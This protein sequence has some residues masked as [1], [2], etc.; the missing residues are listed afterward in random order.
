VLGREIALP[1]QL[2]IDQAGSGQTPKET[3]EIPV[4]DDSNGLPA[5]GL[6]TSTYSEGSSE[7]IRR[8][9][10][11]M[12]GFMP[13]EPR[14]A[15]LLTPQMAVVYEVEDQSA[16]DDLT[17]LASGSP[18]WPQMAGHLDAVHM[19]RDGAL[20]FARTPTRDDLFGKRMEAVTRH[21]R[22]GRGPLDFWE[23]ERTI[24]FRWCFSEARHIEDIEV[25]LA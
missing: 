9:L 13:L 6:W 15:W 23:A 4:F 11:V 24:W 5:G 14:P 22:E 7:Y 10:H 19:T 16:D 3:A 21:V 17:A 25:P 12:E 20:A 2:W 1:Q 18:F 8:I